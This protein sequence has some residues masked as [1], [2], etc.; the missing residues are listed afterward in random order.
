MG[1]TLR[2]RRQKKK[3][4]FIKLNENIEESLISL[5]SWLLNEN[6]LSI[7]YLIPEYF[8]FIGRG[9]KTLK[10]IESNEVLIQLPLRMLITTDVLLQSNIRFL[11]LN[12]ITD[13]FSPQCMLATF[14]VYEAYLGIKVASLFE[15]SV[16][17]FY[18][19][20]FLF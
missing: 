9:L 15:N 13:S 18:K 16:T 11:F 2:K 10:H 17:V 8:P 12:N 6:C 14:L 3:L 19:S 4:N 20:R 1:R 7:Y 5:K